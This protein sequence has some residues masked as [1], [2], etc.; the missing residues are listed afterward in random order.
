VCSSYIPKA[1]AAALAWMINFRD[2]IGQ[3]YA[4]YGSAAGDAQAVRDAVDPFAAAYA[5]AQA[6]P[7]RTRPNIAAKDAARRAAEATCRRYAQMLKTNVALTHQQRAALGL[8]I[9]DAVHSPIPAPQ[10]SPLLTIIAA[11]HL[12]HTLRYADAATPARRA[13]PPGAMQ[14][15]LHRTIGPVAASSPQQ[16]AFYRAFTRQPLEVS[17]SAADQGQVA[18]Y[19]ARW[20]TRTGLVGPWSLPVHMTVAG[21]SAA[22]PEELA[23]ALPT[24][25]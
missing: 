5:T 9:A 11:T 17:F 10:T 1:D 25:A 22:A 19:F 20:A 14:L 23:S 15:Q 21:G 8:T 18:T 24:G 4:A 12:A 16:A 13:K 3:N 2:L 7:T 6:P